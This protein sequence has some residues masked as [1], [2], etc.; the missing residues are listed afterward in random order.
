MKKK[1]L[2][3][4]VAA[5]IAAPAAG[6]AAGPTIYGQAHWSGDYLK[7]DDDSAFAVSQN[8][9]RIGVKGAYDLG[10]GLSAIYLFEWG[11]FLS[12]GPSGSSSSPGL[13]RRNTYAGFKHDT[14]GT[15]VVGRHDTPG[16]IVG[17]KADLFWSTQLGQ[18]RSFTDYQDGSGFG[19]GF[20]QRFDNTI[21]YIS[22]NWGPVHIF[23]AYI[24]D[25]QT[26]VSGIADG[27]VRDASGNP[28]TFEVSDNN[29]FQ[30]FSVAGIYE[31]KNVFTD[32]DLY[33]GISYEQHQIGFTPGVNTANL[34]DKEQALRVG[35]TYGLGNWK[36]AIFFQN[37]TDQGFVDGAD[38]NM[39]G[40]GL[41]YKMGQNTF[42]GQVYA[43]Q[44]LDDTNRL[45]SGN[46]TDA[47]LFAIGWDHAFSKN[48]Q[49]YVQGAGISAGRC[50]NGGRGADTNAAGGNCGTVGLARE[51]RL[52]GAGHGDSVIAT[53]DETT[54]GIS[55]GSRIKF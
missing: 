8:S 10:G 41:A 47:I 30:A 12:D 49:F 25:H 48:V 26:R 42:K 18:N 24:A 38:R 4:A 3:A 16:K 54:F 32:D 27:T 55:F 19:P 7:N 9:S 11:V 51:L 1:L 39:F 21:G 52:G 23:A 43:M 5:S 34:K 44:E 15:V 45:G 40:G 33:I 46:D 50:V 14:Y 35:A 13:S 2:A 31:Q 17:R 20:D 6:M 28:R 37:G 36:F 22:P 29:D 53:P